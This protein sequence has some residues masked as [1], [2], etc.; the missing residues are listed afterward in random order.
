MG[1]KNQNKA[2]VFKTLEE[3]RQF[4]AVISEDKPSKGSKYYRAGRSVAKMACDS[5]VNKTP[6]E[7]TTTDL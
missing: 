4:Y 5:V 3:Y 2:V 7:Q 6:N 1:V